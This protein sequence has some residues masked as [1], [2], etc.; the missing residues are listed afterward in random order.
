MQNKIEVALRILGIAVISLGI[1]IAF[2]I[3]TES[4][5]FTLFFSSILTSLISGFVLLGLAEI[6]K[7]LELIY[8]KLNPLYKQTSLNSL[9]SKQE[10]VENLKANP[11][12]SKEEEDIKKFLQSNHISV[13]KIFATPFED[14][15]IIVTNQERILVEMGGFTPKIIPNEKWPSNL[16]TWYEANKET[17]Q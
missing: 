6:I 9:T 12:G 10:D 14:W 8:I 13:E 11:L 7:Y 1:I 15:F 17:L 4:Q 3:G 2:I 5:S 16:Q